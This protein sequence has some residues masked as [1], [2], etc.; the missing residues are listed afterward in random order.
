MQ[1]YRKYPKRFIGSSLVGCLLLYGGK[2]YEDVQSIKFGGNGEYYAYI[3]DKNAEIGKN[4]RQ[5]Y[6]CED[7]LTIVSILG[8][9]VV[10]RA[11]T[12][13]V[14]CVDARYCSRKDSAYEGARVNRSKTQGCIIQL[15]YE[16]IEERSML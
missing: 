3:V 2:K 9:W 5:V 10:Y 1:S 11:D 12:I 6:E 16:D 4:Y 14:F 7:V 15:L 8:D 13:R